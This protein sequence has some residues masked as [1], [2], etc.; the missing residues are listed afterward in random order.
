MPDTSE[1]K[2]FFQE[3]TQKQLFLHFYGKKYLVHV[4]E[5]KNSCMNNPT[6]PQRSNGPPHTGELTCIVHI[7]L[8][9]ILR[10]KPNDSDR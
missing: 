8:L 9:I 1:K 5:K 4:G 3:S 2:K 10:K 6:P 7:L